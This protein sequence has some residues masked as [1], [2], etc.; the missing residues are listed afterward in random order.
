MLDSLHLHLKTDQRPDGG[1]VAAI[2]KIQYIN[3]EGK[4]KD[5]DIERLRQHD[6]FQHAIFASKAIE[7]NLD[8]DQLLYE[9]PFGK[10]KQT[11]DGKIMISANAS[12][13]TIAIALSVAN[14]IYG[15][16]KIM[17]SE[18]QKFRSKAIVAGGEI[19]L[20]LRF[21]DAEIDKKYQIT[22]EEYRNERANC[23]S[24]F[25][26]GSRELRRRNQA[27]TEVSLPYPKP[28]A[29]KTPTTRERLH[30]SVLSKRFM[31]IH[32]A[33]GAA[34]LLH[35]AEGIHMDYG[36]ADKYSFMRRNF[37]GNGKRREFAIRTEASERPRW[38]LNKERRKNAEDT[39]NRI[40]IKLQETLDRTFAYSHIQY[41]NRENAFQKRGGCIFKGHS[42]PKWAN[43]DP[44]CFFEAADIY[45]RANGERY[46]EI[47]FALP[48]ELPF[49]A[50]KEIVE[51]F[52]HEVLPDHY[53]AYAIH[54][55]IG[56]M[57]DG[58]HN[59]HA[60]I[61]FTTRE[62]DEFEKTVGRDAKTFFSRANKKNPEKGGCP[63]ATKWIKKDRNETLRNEIRPVAA[64]IINEML[65]RYG[66]DSRIS[67]KRLSVR[68]EQAEKEGDFVLAEI[69]H[70]V[71][72]K[73]LDLKIV[74]RDDESVDE[75]KHRRLFK[76]AQT[77]NI[78]AAE[79]MNNLINETKIQKSLNPAKAHLD[80]LLKRKNANKVDLLGLKRQLDKN[81]KIILWSKNSYLAAATKF[82]SPKEKKQFNEF[83][84]LCNTLVGLE[85]M[86]TYSGSEYKADIEER[87]K[88]YKKLVRQEA[89]KVRNIFTRLNL[90]RLD[91]LK[92]QRIMLQKNDVNKKNLV[93][94]LHKIEQIWTKEAEARK[95]INAGKAQ[96][97]KISDVRDLLL[98]Q[99]RSIKESLEVQRTLVTNLKKNVIPYER[100][101]LMAQ[102]KFTGGAYKE[103]RA[104][105]RKL[106]KHESYLKH[107]QAQYQSTLALWREHGEGKPYKKED[108]DIQKNK[109]DARIVANHE[110]R[111]SLEKEQQR[112][113][114]LCSTP[115]AKDMIH[116]I[117]LGIMAKNQPAVQEYETAI[118]RLNV[119]QDRYS[120]TSDR[121][122]A[123]RQRLVNCGDKAVY[124]TTAPR[125]G[126]AANIRAHKDAQTIADGLLGKESAIPRVM[127]SMSGEDDDWSMLT[128]SAKAER[129]AENR[130]REEW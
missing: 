89:V 96:T 78:F 86:L 79:L 9:S 106:A 83:L 69:L 14:R 8:R 110:L 32:K 121:L 24:S 43:N 93:S 28:S 1:R 103:L 34:M 62:N 31:E 80:W 61:M 60:H 88:N 63:K 42:L 67:E 29:G 46:K 84:T 90:Q 2:E 73:H 99:Y 33:T 18:D 120:I 19:D 6:V 100:A 116:K 113:E 104:G 128:E 5:I 26:A 13:E 105:L 52:I 39:A 45:E 82:M 59:V 115:T 53:Y 95:K 91:V 98:E 102:G 3:R 37:N 7:R 10:I 12:V 36:S 58:V 65:D 40:L 68:K 38:N 114:V 66:F 127:Q 112:L 111:K 129:A 76:I 27:G 72:E 51:N 22:L 35:T 44:K 81:A 54:D 41:I 119:L 101:V 74:L 117:A 118:E 56:Q 17:L 97:Y 122:E 70:R 15:N 16:E 109:I 75:L 64:S 123:V 125:S 30:V 11:A 85:K 126:S 107:D 49:E 77:K 71:P 94:T 124:K 47:E 50:Q 130:F 87:L 92:E 25:L 20:P 55:K 21:V 4:Y 48:N 108:L 23:N 57:S